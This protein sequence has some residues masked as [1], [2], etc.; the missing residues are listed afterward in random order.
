MTTGTIRR[1]DAEIAMRVTSLHL[2]QHTVED[3]MRSAIFDTARRD[4]NGEIEELV[5][6]LPHKEAVM[7]IHQG[8]TQAEWEGNQDNTPPIP[9]RASKHLGYV[10]ERAAKRDTEKVQNGVGHFLAWAWLT[11]PELFNGVVAAQPGTYGMGTLRAAANVLGLGE[12]WDALSAKEPIVRLMAD[13]L[14]S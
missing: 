5:F 7:F 11:E 14:V 2:G 10:I 6:A 4:N 13:G 8:T 3:T 1:T 12:E 9:E